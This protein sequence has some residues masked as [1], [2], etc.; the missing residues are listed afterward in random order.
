MNAIDATSGRRR[1]RRKIEF[2]I[3]KNMLPRGE[4]KKATVAAIPSIGVTT[5]EMASLGSLSPP[6]GG[7]LYP[8]LSDV[9]EV[10]DGKRKGELNDD[11][12]GDI[13]EDMD[14]LE[15]VVKPITLLE[16][17]K[18]PATA[19]HWFLLR[20]MLDMIDSTDFYVAPFLIASNE[21][22]S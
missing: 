18:I 4:R 8:I 13:I 15:G 1:R 10:Y 7:R 14:L 2:V 17:N 19:R 16:H 20:N 11:T 5:D 22:L 9:D 3:A 12:A 21:C 6:P